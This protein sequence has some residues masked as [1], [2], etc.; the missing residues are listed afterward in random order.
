MAGRA[1]P[2]LWRDLDLGEA[3]EVNQVNVAPVDDRTVVTI[4]GRTVGI[5][6]EEWR[7]CCEAVYVL[8]LPGRKRAEYLEGVRKFRG[9]YGKAYLEE[10]MR[11]IEHA[12]VLAMPT[13]DDRREYLREVEVSRGVG[14]RE[15]LEKRIVALWV[16]RQS[17]SG[18]V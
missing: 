8:A 3:D 12:F 9:E 4:D 11:D 13:R 5:I 7:R 1:F 14:T 18:G 10:E 16:N 15:N 2:R 17:Q 6:S